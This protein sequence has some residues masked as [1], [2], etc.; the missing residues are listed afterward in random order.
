M[1]PFKPGTS[2]DKN[3]PIQTRNQWGQKH[4][5]SNPE[6]VGTKISPLKPGTSGDKNRRQK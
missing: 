6:P 1:S 2:G 5:H 4:P 3:I